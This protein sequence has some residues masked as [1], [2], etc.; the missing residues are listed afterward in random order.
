[1]PPDFWRTSDIIADGTLCV[2]YTMLNASLN[3]ANR[4]VLGTYG[5][6]FPALLTSAHM[7]FNMVFLAP[8]MVLIPSYRTEHA[9]L[10][11]GNWM[12]L[13]VIAVLNVAQ[14]TLN[15]SSLVHIELSMNQVVRATLPV[16]VA[17]LDSVCKTPPP[18]HHMVMLVT[19]SLGANLVVY[20]PASVS[21][22]KFQGVV[23]V[24]LSVIMQ[25]S[26]M[27]FAGSLLSGKFDA[28]QITFYT[29]PI[30]LLASIGPASLVEGYQF[31]RFIAR[32]P[33]LAFMALAGTSTLAA[34]YNVVVFQTIQRLSAVGSAV[35]GNVKVVVLLFLSSLLM[36]EMQSWDSSQLLGCALTFSGA[37]VY[38][39]FKLL[40]ADKNSRGS[41]TWRA[42]W[43]SHSAARLSAASLGFPVVMLVAFFLI[44]G[45]YIALD[46]SWNSQLLKGMKLNGH[47]PE[48]ELKGDGTDPCRNVTVDARRGRP[49]PAPARGELVLITGGSGFIGSHLTTRLLELGYSV[50]V[51]DNLE[52]GN[53]L[54]LE[55]RAPRLEFYYGDILDIEALRVAMVGVKGIF[56]LGAASK[57]LPS[58]KDPAMA[59]FNYERNAIG[60]SRVLQAANETTS[61]Q[62]VIYAASSTYYGNQEVPFRETDSFRPTSPYAASKYM[63][64]LEMLTHDSLY[65]LDTLSLR[66]FM[67]YGPRNPSQGAYAIVT[68]KFLG[69]LQEG[70]PLVIEGTG[71]NFRDFVHVQ[72]IARA[73]ILGYQSKVHGTVINVGTGKAYSVK[74]VADIVSSNQ[75]HV[76]PRPNDLLGTLADTCRAK[77][78][79]H[80]EAEYDFLATM[81]QMITDAK[82]GKAKYLAPMWED[83]QVV[84]A[85]DQRLPGWS[86]LPSSLDQSARIREALGSD[87]SFLSGLLTELGVSVSPHHT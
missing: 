20:Q 27:C 43:S 81:R 61:V 9:R 50:R 22:S 55:L 78:L 23:L 52:T 18:L 44:C 51:F 36:G 35:L 26:Q 84:K 67:V 4:L 47:C 31:V 38:S 34:I 83:P 8:V 29:S 71:E 48:G 54:Y 13:A 57:V 24:T 49:L 42:L 75:V 68:G 14:I 7:F 73:L 74:D 87:H 58:L 60:T 6:S 1:M 77:H 86:S 3:S 66:F 40:S 39:S 82:A 25:A 80:F 46:R 56:H 2:L 33:R 79:L 10:F 59:T 69:R 11:C 72:D 30:A 32:N 12:E 16:F 70:Q 53:L 76:A 37:A 41:G 5:F 64:E 17:L 28:L 21:G 65:H 62:K 45:D 63:G 85:V 19:I 15:N